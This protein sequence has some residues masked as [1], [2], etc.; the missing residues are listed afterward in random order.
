MSDYSLPAEYRGNSCLPTIFAGLCAI[1]CF[2]LGWMIT[3]GPK[4]LHLIIGLILCAIGLLVSVYFVILPP[5]ALR[6][7]EE[8]VSVAK[9]QLI[10]WQDIASYEIFPV[11]DE[12]ELLGIKFH[13]QAKSNYG[14]EHASETPAVVRTK[15]DYTINLLEFRCSNEDWAEHLTRNVCGTSSTVLSHEAAA[16]TIA[17]LAVEQLGKQ[18]AKL[19]PNRK[20]YLLEYPGLAITPLLL[21]GLLCM[22]LFLKRGDIAQIAAVPPLMAGL[23]VFGLLFWWHHFFTLKRRE[24]TVFENGIRFEQNGNQTVAGWYQIQSLTTDKQRLDQFGLIPM[25]TKY[26]IAL[27]DGTAFQYSDLLNGK[28]S[29]VAKFIVKK[30]QL[31]PVPSKLT[32]AKIY[33][34]I[35]Q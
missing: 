14:K 1:G 6:F 7:T 15:F 13:D 19:G 22:F 26:E 23:S 28:T 9:Q 30:A 18:L 3:F 2:L 11:A 25:F 20:R 5:I 17:P 4:E 10:R 21:V 33:Q 29:E 34:K 35:P 8:G 31:S 27:I 24:V 12:A 16:K 32:T